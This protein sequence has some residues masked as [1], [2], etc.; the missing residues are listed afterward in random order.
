MNRFAWKSYHGLAAEDR[1]GAIK[2]RH[3]RGAN[4]LSVG[5]KIFQ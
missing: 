1:G 3:P 5:Q 2:D 4:Q